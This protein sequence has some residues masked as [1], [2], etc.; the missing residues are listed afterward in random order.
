MKP[1]KTHWLLCPSHVVWDRGSNT[2]LHGDGTQTERSSSLAEDLNK[3]TRSSHSNSMTRDA[4]RW[5]TTLAKRIHWKCPL[6]SWS[7]HMP[8][9]VSRN[10]ALPVFLVNV[11]T[12]QEALVLELMAT[13]LEETWHHCLCFLKLCRT[14]RDWICLSLT[15]LS[16][17]RRTYRFRLTWTISILLEYHNWIKYCSSYKVCN[18]PLDPRI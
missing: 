15:L 2:G 12:I 7:V 9:L 6:A 17:Q 3:S 10:H 18:Y 4:D 5:S 11:I 8:S 14:W 13:L 1:L 16:I